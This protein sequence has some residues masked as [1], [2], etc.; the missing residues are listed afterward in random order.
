M[1]IEYG[2][3]NKLF[4]SLQTIHFFLL[5][6]YQNQEFYTKIFMLIYLLKLN[7]FIYICLPL[8]CIIKFI[9]CQYFVLLIFFSNSIYNTNLY[10]FILSFTHIYIKILTSIDIYLWIRVYHFT[11]F[12]FFFLD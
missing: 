8:L 9:D 7:L 4:Y 2:N 1:Y 5:T 11:N 12:I 3:V 10:L 6:Y